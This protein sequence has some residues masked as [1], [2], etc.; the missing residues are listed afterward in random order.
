MLY[1]RA[2][3]GGALLAGVFGTL[4]VSAW[5]AAAQQQPLPPGSPLLGRPD[6]EAAKKLA[7]IAPPPIPTASP[8]GR[9]R[10]AL[11]SAREG[12]RA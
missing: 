11:G 9:R 10:A 8:H 2:Q 7:P 1:R 6:T 12:E 5:P 3:R 4:L